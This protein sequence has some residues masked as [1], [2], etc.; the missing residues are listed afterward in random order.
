M[1]TFC[2]LSGI[3]IGIV[4][5]ILFLDYIIG[6]NFLQ[7]FIE[8]ESLSIMGNML[9]IYVGVVTAFIAI[10]DNLYKMFKITC[11]NT[12]KSL[13]N[14]ILIMLLLYGLQMVCLVATPENYNNNI[15]IEYL[16]K[17]LEVLCLTLYFLMFYEVIDVFFTAKEMI[18]KKNITQPPK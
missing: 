2:I 11:S 13:K 1:R 10:L 18:Q 17:G 7:K 16:I 14:N 8:A 4:F 12:Q 6:N 15:W 3:M 9:A 5:P